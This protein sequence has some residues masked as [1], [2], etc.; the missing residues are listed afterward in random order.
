MKTFDIK[1]ADEEEEKVYTVKDD[2]SSGTYL[3]PKTKNSLPA[4]I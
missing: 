3:S 4:Y 1:A 2:A